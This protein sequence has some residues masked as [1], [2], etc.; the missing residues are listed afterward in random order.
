MCNC[1]K[2]QDDLG[3]HRWAVRDLNPRPLACHASALPTAPTARSGRRYHQ[4]VAMKP[5]DVW[6]HVPAH[7]RSVMPTA[8]V[9]GSV[10]R[11]GPLDGLPTSDLWRRSCSTRWP[12]RSPNSR[13]A[14]SRYVTMATLM[15]K[16][17]H[18]EHA[19]PHG[20]LVDL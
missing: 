1:K 2:P 20:E 19:H 16:R 7:R 8:P 10:R 3:F 6:T 18:F 12:P 4:P 9:T 5:P 14:N 15:T 13:L 11:C 17:H